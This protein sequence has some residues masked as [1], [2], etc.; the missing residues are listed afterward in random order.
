MAKKY[1][2]LIAILVTALVLVGGFFSY[3][4]YAQAEKCKK[5]ARDQNST[6]TLFLVTSATQ[7]EIDALK[8][9]VDSSE[10]VQS[11]AY[12][13]KEQALKDY[14]EK[15]RER[16]KLLDGISEEEN[17]LP[18][19]LTI[20]LKDPTDRTASENLKSTL[21][22]SQN[23]IINDVTWPQQYELT[24][25]WCKDKKSVLADAIDNIDKE[26]TSDSE[27]EIVFNPSPRPEAS[28]QASPETPP[29]C[30][31]GGVPRIELTKP[32][33]NE[34][35]NR[36]PTI[37]GTGPHPNSVISVS[38]DGLDYLFPAERSNLTVNDNLH[39][40]TDADGRFSFALDLNGGQVIGAGGIDT[41]PNPREVNLGEHRIKIST[42]STQGV[43]TDAVADSCDVV[44]VL[45]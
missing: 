31:Q 17:P 41:P 13:S 29:S 7:P 12:V 43:G 3:K 45:R 1:K 38:I 37:E 15:N 14:K 32:P 26:K 19:S 27:P 18:A 42:G 20:K 44:V 11:S 21:E 10:A 9:S 39:P 8:K 36:T 24:Y 40:K 22:K 35:I 30:P 25:K 16:S 33:A 28:A 2:I 4:E 23:G 34:F 5:E 6:I